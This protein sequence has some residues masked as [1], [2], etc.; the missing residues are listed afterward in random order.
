MKTKIVLRKSLGWLL[1]AGATISVGFLSFAGMFLLFPSLALCSIAFILAAAY[2][3]QVNNE[4]I[5]MALRRMFGKDY[6]KKNIIRRHLKE[7]IEPKELDNIFLR[8]YQKNAHYL[9]A[10]KK[11]IQQEQEI[12]P[13]TE[14]EQE[15]KKH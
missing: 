10:L 6:L 2:E 12:H 11:Y 8:K 4:S 15:E 7:L 5:S 14:K 9:K 13:L 3:G 1:A